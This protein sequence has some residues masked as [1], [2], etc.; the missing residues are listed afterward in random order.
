MR[1]DL[2]FI[3]ADRDKCDDNGVHRSA[4]L[5][6]SKMIKQRHTIEFSSQGCRITD[7]GEIYSI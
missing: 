2:T 5:Q 1:G 6:V 7:D 3:A 4:S